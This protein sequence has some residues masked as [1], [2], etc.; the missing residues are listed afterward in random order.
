MDRM[1]SEIKAFPDMIM[2][3]NGDNQ[4]AGQST[5]RMAKSIINHCDFFDYAIT[6]TT[7]KNQREYTHKYVKIKKNASQK[8]V[9]QMVANRKP[10]T[11]FHKYIPVEADSF[12][13]STFID[14]TVLYKTIMTTIREELADG[15]AICDKWQSFQKENGFDL[16]EDFLSWISGEY[17]AMS[18]PPTQPTPF[19]TEDAAL[20]VR[21]KDPVKAAQ[22][23]NA[24]IQ[25]AAKFMNN[26]NQPLAINDATGIPVKGF[27]TITIASM[28][29]IVGS[30]C[31][32]IWE[33]WFVFGSNEAI[34]KK[35]MATTSG[36]AKSIRDNVRF[37]QEGIFLNEPVQSVSF[38]DLRTVSQQLTG[39]LVGMGFT[40]GM[41]PNE[42]DT[43]PLKAGAEFH[44]AVESCGGGIEFLQIHQQCNSL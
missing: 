5:K 19:C 17:I 23:L 39:F 43:L 18:T 15:P 27:K 33:D 14:L 40:A 13:A 36:K 10:I 28:A 3:Q 30:P 44:R 11:N 1:L 21:V 31:V 2:G 4:S 9:F 34:V 20:L 38:T 35:I 8:P 25:R 7:V 42:P 12:E 16:Q 29:M 37:Q 24:G 26:Q 6:T 22:K 32:G 41:I